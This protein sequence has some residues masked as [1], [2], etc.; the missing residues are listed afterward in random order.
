MQIKT[1]VTLSIL[2]LFMIFVIQNLT[3]VSVNFL[4]FEITMPRALLL[5]LCLLI[6]VLAGLF[7]PFEFKK[8]K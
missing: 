3:S 8:N 1:V 2:F 7:L 6:G 4:V 5:I